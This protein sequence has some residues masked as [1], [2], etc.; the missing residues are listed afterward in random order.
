MATPKSAQDA[1]KEISL[2]LGEAQEL[3]DKAD[4]IIEQ[5]RKIAQR[6]DLV[7]EKR[8]LDALPEVLDPDLYEIKE[9]TERWGGKTHTEMRKVFKKDLPKKLVDHC[10]IIPGEDVESCWIPSS[11]C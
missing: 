10:Y 5:C 4:Q 11:L 7:F 1:Y 2:L 9:V 8:Y 6:N 3:K